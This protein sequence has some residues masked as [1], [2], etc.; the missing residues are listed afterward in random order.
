MS[1]STSGDVPES[2]LDVLNPGRDSVEVALARL[3]RWLCSVFGALGAVSLLFRVAIE[4][5]DSNALPVA[6]LG[7]QPV[8]DV[9]VGPE[10]LLDRSVF[11]LGLSCCVATAS[12]NMRVRS[13]R[14][15]AAAVCGG[16]AGRLHFVFQYRKT[17]SRA[18]G[19]FSTSRSP[20]AFP[21]F[22]DQNDALV[23]GAGG[24]DSVL[25][26]RHDTAIL[27]DEVSPGWILGRTL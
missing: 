24:L 5:T 25:N 7:D 22:S 26:G 4:M 8:D 6:S 11:I 15:V 9:G 3:M 19:G 17:V 12:R 18:R 21:I 10:I 13:A 14:P 16:F 2:G 23:T 27:A 1:Q 20:F